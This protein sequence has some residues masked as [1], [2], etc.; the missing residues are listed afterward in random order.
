MKLLTNE[1]IIHSELSMS[2]DPNTFIN[3]SEQTL[4]DDSKVYNILI[5]DIRIECLDEQSANNLIFILNQEGKYL[6]RP[7]I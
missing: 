7:N 4:T 5:G 3:I 2:G 1:K 6:V